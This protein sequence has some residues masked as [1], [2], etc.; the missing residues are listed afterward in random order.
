MDEEERIR[1]FCVA[2][3]MAQRVRVISVAGEG[4]ETLRARQR[5][6]ESARVVDTDFQKCQ[7]DWDEP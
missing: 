2:Y 5:E 1:R 4:S 6:A 3:A 7:T